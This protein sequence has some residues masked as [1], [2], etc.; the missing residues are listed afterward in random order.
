MTVHVINLDRDTERLE[1]FRRLNAHVGEIRRVAAFD[2]AKLD[3]AALAREGF[4]E[5]DLRYSNGSLGNARSH[6]TLWRQAVE[7][8]AVM[9]IAEDDAVFAKHFSETSTAFLARLPADWHIVLW[10]WNFD[11][12]LWAEIPEG[13]S[14]CKLEFNQ[15]DLRRNLEEFRNHHQAHAPVRLRH[16]F[17]MLAYSVSPHGARA[18][19]DLCLP[20][21]NQRVEFP[22]FDVVIENRSFDSTLNAVYPRLKAYACMPPLAASENLHESSR[23]NA[24]EQVAQFDPGNPDTLP[25]PVAPALPPLPDPAPTVMLA[26]LARNKAHLLADF[27]RCVEALDYPKSSI[28]LYVRT[29]D[30]GDDT[31]PI[32]RAWLAQHGA[33]YRSVDFDH[34]R[35]PRAEAIALEHHDNPHAWATGR[36][37]VLAQIREASLRAAQKLGSDYYFVVDCDNFITPWTLRALIDLRKPIAAPM[38]ETVPRV[39][40]YSNYFCGVDANG[41]YAEHPEYDDIRWRRRSGVFEVPLVHCTYL[42]AASAL[43]QLAYHDDGPESMEFVTFARVARTQGIDQWI[44]NRH[45]YGE[46]LYFEG[47]A[48]STTLQQEI[49]VWKKIREQVMRRVLGDRPPAPAAPSG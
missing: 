10:G 42:I 2:G 4:C 8:S 27:L 19:L 34:R 43:P 7:Q 36:L 18:L 11:A 6:M 29:N 23:T 25:P 33:R 20:I 15:D 45:G 30:N 21:K 3:R 44:D 1:Q 16:A 14:R 24:W 32:L 26:I 17:G 46:L 5:P 37:R 48:E 22:G 38:L 28:D 40:R 39:M 41:Y 49:E 47:E 13:V 35:P 9:T 31:E 12:F